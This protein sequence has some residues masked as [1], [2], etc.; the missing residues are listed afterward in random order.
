MCAE[1]ESSLVATFASTSVSREEVGG[2]L[3]L[4]T[5]FNHVEIGDGTSL[6]YNGASLCVDLA[7]TDDVTRWVENN[8]FSSLSAAEIHHA[9]ERGHITEKSVDDE[10]SAFRSEIAC[11]VDQ[12]QVPSNCHKRGTLYLVLTYACNLSCSYC[13]QSAINRRSASPPMSAEFA[14]IVLSNHLQRLFPGV[15][16]ENIRI[17]LFGGEPLLPGNRKTIARVLDFAR[18]NKM[19]VSAATN[20]TTLDTMCDFVGP[21]KIANVQ[22]TLDGD[23]DF[24][25]R[26]RIPSSGKPT[27]KKMIEAIHTLIKREVRVFIRVHVHPTNLNS[28]TRLIDRLDRDLVLGHP[29][30]DLYFTPINGFDEDEASVEFIAT[31][32][33]L[34]Q[35]VAARTGFPPTNNFAFLKRFLESNSRG[36]IGPVP[37]RYCGLGSST[38][39][40]DGSGGVYNCSQEEGMADRRVGAILNNELEYYPLLE[41]YGDRHIMNIAECMKCSVAIFCRGGCAR[42]ALTRKGSI[43]APYC[44]QNR[45]L[46]GQTFKAYFLKRARV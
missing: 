7:A 33:K 23:E 1:I 44:H 3:R 40:V 41:S 15:L 34:F 19:L 14:D 2:I 37:L 16:T 32:R 22:I 43:F 10:F 35:R 31:F 18:R 25:D 36:D 5:Y 26:H 9:L 30:V 45:E 28:V 42:Q 6:I 27:F 11:L 20:G 4:S 29:K 38:R 39:I 21:G 8:D 17:I 46:I 12:N 13:F 24:H